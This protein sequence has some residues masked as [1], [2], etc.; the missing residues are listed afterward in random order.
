MS[1]CFSVRKLVVEISPEG[2][3]VS[4]RC[5]KTLPELIRWFKKNAHSLGKTAGSSG[6]KVNR[7]WLCGI[8][9]YC[10]ISYWRGKGAIKCN[11][12]GERTRQDL[13]R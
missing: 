6:R 4:K 1:L 3:V 9:V 12:Q 5:F 7:L 2:F 8:Y 10:I 13:N 11:A